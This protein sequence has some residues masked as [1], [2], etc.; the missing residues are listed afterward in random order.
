MHL[1]SLREFRQWPRDGDRRPHLIG[2]L[3]DVSVDL[4]SHRPRDLPL[5]VQAQ[6]KIR[7]ILPH[8]VVARQVAPA[9]AVR[10]HR[11]CSV[12]VGPLADAACGS[13]RGRGNDRN[14]GIFRGIPIEFKAI[15]QIVLWI[16]KK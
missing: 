9:A 16:K 10:A 8:D 14:I 3:M 11:H 13:V 7:D 15:V 12:D 4:L 1:G 5:T 2:D 6:K